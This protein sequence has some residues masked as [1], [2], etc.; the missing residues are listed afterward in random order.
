MMTVRILEDNPYLK[1]GI[2]ELPDNV[3][4]ELI[5]KGLAVIIREKA[6]DN[7]ALNDLDNAKRR[8]ETEQQG[9]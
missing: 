1:K 8:D 2:I 4:R 9:S 6:V 3:A 7:E 5:S